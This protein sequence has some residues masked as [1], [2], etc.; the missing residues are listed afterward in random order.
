MLAIRAC[1]L[2]HGKVL[3]PRP[4]VRVIR[5]TSSKAN[6]PHVSKSTPSETAANHSS[7]Q[8]PQLKEVLDLLSAYE[9]RYTYRGW[10]VL[11]LVGVGLVTA[12]A[13]VFYFWGPIRRAISREGSELAQQTMQDEN[14]QGEV[15][16]ITRQTTNTLL[17]D[18]KT[19]EVTVDFLIRLLQKPETRT[20]VVSFFSKVI[21]DPTTVQ[22]LAQLL[23]DPVTVRQLQ[24]SLNT[25]L[26]DPAIQASLNDLVFALLQDEQTQQVLEKMVMDLL[27]RPHVKAS[28][29]DFFGQVLQYPQVIDAATASSKDVVA[30]LSRDE[31]IHKNLASAG[32]S[33]VKRMVIPGFM[34]RH[35]KDDDKHGND[36]EGKKLEESDATDDTDCEGGS[37]SIDNANELVKDQEES[38]GDTL[39]A[40]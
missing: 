18:P 35:H 29:A 33:A 40:Q 38:T 13:A 8:Q 7:T 21:A 36:D 28:T 25:L 27:Q 16:R 5:L 24:S 17:N 12:G 30:K 1:R 20:Y 37:S 23:K 6:R 39:P 10:H 11:R 32:S 2:C 14:L 15:D 9:N 31:D 4:T 22:A 34:F 19:V 26:K 3:F